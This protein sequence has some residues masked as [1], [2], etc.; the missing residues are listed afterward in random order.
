MPPEEPGAR[1]G[2]VVAEHLRRPRR[3]AD[4]ASGA[5][6]S[7]PGFD[8]EDGCAVDGVEFFDVQV[9]AVDFDEAT[10]GDAEPVEAAHVAV[11]EGADFGPVGVVPGTA[12]AEVQASG[13]RE[14][15]PENDL[16]VGERVQTFGGVGTVLQ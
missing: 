3:L 11:A 7:E 13:V 5:E 14:M 4:V 6:L 10:A 8:V 2:K 16:Q 9:E 1:R 15:E 12:G